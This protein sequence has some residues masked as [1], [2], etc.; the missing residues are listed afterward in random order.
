MKK[1]FKRI[2]YLIMLMS[3]L[4]MALLFVCAWNPEMTQR[5]AQIL[6]P[7]RQA[8][9]EA[10][11]EKADASHG[12]QET[13]ASATDSETTETEIPETESPG[14]MQSGL[15]EENPAVYIAPEKSE[16]SVPQE[17]AGKSGYQEI[18]SNDNEIEE[19]EAEEL[20]HQLGVGETGDGLTFDPLYYPYYNML[21]ENGQRIYRQIYANAKVVNPSFAPVEPVTAQK[22]R[23]VISA[24]YN[25]HPELFWL[26]T[27]YACKH[28][29]NGQCV[30]IDLQFNRTAKNLEGENA[31]FERAANEIISQAAGFPSDYD[32]ECYVHD[33]LLRNI[34]YVKSAEMNQSAYSAL[35][36]GRT[37]CAG[38]ARAFQY[39]MQQL[40]VPCYYCV[41]YAGEDHAWNIIKLEEEYYN[42]DLTWDDTGEGTYD[43]FNKTDRDYA[44]THMRQELSV[45]LP[46][47]NGEK[48]RS[49]DNT[50]DENL[51][52]IEDIGYSE[53]AV[54][55]SL[56][57]YYDSCY[58]QIMQRGA[59]NYTFTSVVQGKE[60]YEE[61]EQAYQ[62]DTY[63]E[64]Y[65]IEAMRGIGAKSCHL[66]LAV[67]D[68]Q[69]DRY[70]LTHELELH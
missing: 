31:A 36:N 13:E 37:V 1:F 8:E 68:L 39:V 27:S 35:V 53:A 55:T 38:Y 47:C 64:E 28:R 49:A 44:E 16:L 23:D 62:S 3:A 51:R 9:T 63:K 30:E 19:T 18:Q 2:L 25:D 29:G 41:G 15:S 33:T 14:S 54:F 67:E 70:L 69:Q 10:L 50:T 6:Y 21:D 34:E 46:A 56:S 60:L 7:D 12:I 57:D 26:D 42:V 24:V 61:L 66:N 43:Y 52:S 32:K 22:L 20:E 17:V 40:G 48:Y 58:E 5:I 11:T 65:L 45:Y 59:G 4:L